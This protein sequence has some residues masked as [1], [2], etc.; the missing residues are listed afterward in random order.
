[1]KLFIAGTNMRRTYG[2]NKRVKRP[3]APYDVF[4]I[5]LETVKNQS[6]EL[7]K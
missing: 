4:M 6:Q 1:M 3:L 7:A 2:L 5:E